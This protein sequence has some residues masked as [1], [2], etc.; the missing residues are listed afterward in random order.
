MPLGPDGTSAIGELMGVLEND[1][2]NYRLMKAAKSDP[3][4]DAKPIITGWMS[5]QNDDVYDDILNSIEPKS[6]DAVDK[7]QNE[8]EPEVSSDEPEVSSDDLPAA[9]PPAAPA[10]NNALPELPSLP[11]LPELPPVKE[12]HLFRDPNIRALKHAVQVNES[13]ERIKRLSGL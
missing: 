2:L 3:N 5:E 12:E 4:R 8:P 6:D 10:Q 1:E 13:L 9:P 11:D 7:D